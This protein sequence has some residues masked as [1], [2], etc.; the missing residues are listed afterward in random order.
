[1]LVVTALVLLGI[2]V[3]TRP[4]STITPP[5]FAK[6][7]LFEKFTDPL[8]VKAFEIT[9]FDEDQATI[10]PFKAAVVDG[11]WSI[12]SQDNYPADANRQLALATAELVGLERLS[13][14]TDRKDEHSVYG[15]IDPTDTKNLSVGVKGVGKHVKL[16]ESGDNTLVDLII[17]KE[18]PTQAGIRFVRLPGRDEVY[19]C[20]VDV[21]K[22]TTKFH[23]WIETDL[24][25]LNALDIQRLTVKD[26]SVDE[27]RGALSYRGEYKV[28]F[29][30]KESKWSLDELKEVGKQ[31]FEV[32]KLT[33]EQEL[34]S[35]KLND[36]KNALDD[37]K[38]VDVERKPKGLA[39]DLAVSDDLKADR[40]KVQNLM[41]RGFFPA[42]VTGPDGTKKLELVS[43]EGEVICAMNDGV[44][45]VLRFGQIAGK[46]SETNEEKKDDEKK[47][48]DAKEGG[49]DRFIMVSA[50]FN[51]DL[52]PKPALKPEPGT[53][54]AQAAPVIKSE[55]P[56]TKPADEKKPEGEKKPEPAK[57]EPAKTDAPKT[58]TK[59]APAK[60]EPAKTA[61]AKT[62]APKTEAKQPAKTDAPKTD[63]PKKEA[64]KSDA[65]TPEKKEGGGSGAFNLFDDVTKDAKDTKAAPAKDD[66]AATPAK[67]EPAKEQPKTDTPK[68]D[69]PKTET[70]TDAK[71]AEAP[72]ADDKAADEA[73]QRQEAEL[74]AIRDENKRLQDEYD[75]KLEAGK[76]R[77][78]ELN[79]RF[80]TWYYI[81]GDSVYRKIHVTTKDVI[82]KKDAP[83]GD[84]KPDDKNDPISKFNDLKD[85]GLDQ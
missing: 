51:P 56:G 52:I 42:Q 76:K 62:E 68:T 64:P 27:L 85:K 55:G 40:E 71:P 45:Y 57:T 82:K 15:V 65:K 23:E 73:K 19:T 69:T 2:T 70:K 11:L 41:Q 20:K 34:D 17:G 38:I 83:A 5:D 78:E 8:A 44:E 29:D 36:M 28:R 7:P 46:S 48:A 79:R 39:A 80:S 59:A 67:T 60:T 58:E 43:N 61:P 22:L 21:S 24:L 63:A 77:V 13:K 30:S 54:G 84:K 53:P 72:K 6:G 32:V 14:V 4:G 26:Y 37:L 16:S 81:I 3:L 35:A 12:P 74:K 10:K 49:V 18:D 25:K 66:K 9:D 31:G 1:S 47:P 33:P 50:R 75:A